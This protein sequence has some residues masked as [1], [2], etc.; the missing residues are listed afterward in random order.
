MWDVTY[1]CDMCGKRKGEANHWWMATLGGS[2]KAEAGGRVGEARLSLF[3]W[4]QAESQ[5]EKMYHLCG[6]GCA[7]QA[8]E[9]YMDEGTLG[10]E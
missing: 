9:R 1:T 6:Q 4:S 8:L 7:V 5:D 10:A 3:R 2:R